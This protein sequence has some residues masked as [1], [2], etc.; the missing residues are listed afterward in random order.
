MQRVDRLAAA[1]LERIRDGKRCDDLPVDRRIH[2]RLA[3]VRHASGCPGERFVVIVQPSH[4][5]IRP[6]LDLVPLHRR[7]DSE[8]G[9]RTECGG[10]PDFEPSAAGCIDDGT[11]DRMFARVLRRGNQ[12]QHPVVIAL[13]NPQVRQLRLPLRH[14]PGLVQHH[15]IDPGHDLERST[16]AKQRAHLRSLASADHD[17]RRRGKPHGTRTGNNQHADR[18]HKCIIEGW[19]WTDPQPCRE[20]DCSDEND[21]R[22]KNTGD[23][24]RELLNR[25]LAGL[26][27]FD[28]PDDL[29]QHGIGANPGRTKRES[30]RLVDRATN[31]F[32]IAANLDRNRLTGHHRDIDVTAAIDDD[33]V[34]GNS[35]ARSHPDEVVRD[36]LSDRNFENLPRAL[37]AR[38]LGLQLDQLA[39]RCRRAPLGP[40]LE[41]LAGEYQRDD[42]RGSL[43]IQVGRPLG[44]QPR[45]NDGDHRVEVGGGAAHDD[46]RAHSRV[47]MPN[48]AP[49]LVIKAVTCIEL[50]RRR[51]QQL[52][53]VPGA[54]R[55]P[56]A[57]GIAECRPRHRRHRNRHERDRQACADDDQ[58]LQL[59]LLPV[60]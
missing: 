23:S 51:Q 30:T 44:K 3:L 33:T 1:L 42:G 43:E 40:G 55:Q 28:Q 54:C 35:L 49:R 60:A 31:D 13:R 32:R 59:G 19:R 24:I 39:D 18:G 20:R 57:H 53:P 46:Q 58:P 34:D 47:E 7:L 26:C 6:D 2:R 11:R 27:L 5:P 48:L 50:H 36:H 17:R 16:L 45:G 9:N 15:R 14:R 21:G 29:R 25:G 10:C 37:D 38:R 8:S 22:H 41:V 56:G 4:E 52:E 12:L